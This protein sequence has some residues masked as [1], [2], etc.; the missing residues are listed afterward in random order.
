[1][2]ARFSKVICKS[3]AYSDISLGSRRCQLGVSDREGKNRSGVS[4]LTWNKFILRN[5]ER[6]WSNNDNL[7]S[8]LY[9]R[10]RYRENS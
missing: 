8:I 9:S 6:A 3:F 2:E 10:E 1:M 4:L 7:L 5:N